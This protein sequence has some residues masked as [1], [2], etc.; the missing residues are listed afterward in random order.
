MC[1]CLPPTLFYFHYTQQKNQMSNRYWKSLKHTCVR[2]YQKQD[3]IDDVAWRKHVYRHHQPTG[4]FQVSKRWRCSHSRNEKNTRLRPLDNNKSQLST[5]AMFN[6]PARITHNAIPKIESH[7]TR[8]REYMQRISLVYLW[9]ACHYL[10]S[11]ID[12]CQKGE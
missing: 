12:L 11:F 9:T 5:V 10:G 8:E 4:N 3:K 6:R 7:N 2:K 1:S